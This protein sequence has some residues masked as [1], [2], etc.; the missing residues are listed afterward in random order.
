VTARIRVGAVALL[1]VL[2]VAGCTS[3]DAGNPS[4]APTTT[5]K[6]TESLPPRPKDIALDKVDPC[7]LWTTVQQQQLKTYRSN[8]G[9]GQPKYGATSCVFQVKDPV[10]Y[11]SSIILE[12]KR[13][14]EDWLGGTGT[15]QTRQVQVGS[16]PAIQIIAKGLSWDGPGGLDCSTNVSVTQGQELE[17]YVQSHAHDLSQAQMCDLSKAGAELALATLQTIK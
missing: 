2:G 9:P 4:A 11:T 15:V 17:I 13:G 10:A 1:S 8:P 7:S 12:T 16:F 3:V 6:S 14:A 5:T